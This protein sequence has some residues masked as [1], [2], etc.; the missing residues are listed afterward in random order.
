MSNMF[1]VRYCYIYIRYISVLLDVIFSYAKSPII[2]K[3]IFCVDYSRS[4]PV[5]WFRIV[6]VQGGEV[7]FGDFPLGFNSPT[8]GRICPLGVDLVEAWVLQRQG[9]RVVAKKISVP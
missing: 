5:F 8:I 3:N 6:L 9:Q 7:H 4:D 1:A 2:I